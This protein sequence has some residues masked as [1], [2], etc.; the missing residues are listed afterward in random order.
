M[1]LGTRRL[2][3]LQL[4]SPA[5]RFD[6][7]LSN[8]TKLHLATAPVQ[9]KAQWYNDS[10][11]AAIDNAIALSGGPAWEEAGFATLVELAARAM[12]E[13]LEQVASAISLIVEDLATIEPALEALDGTAVE[14]SIR[15]VR[16][17]LA[18]LTY[19]GFVAGVGLERIDD[20]ARYIS[21]I[22]HRIGNLTESPA[23]DLSSAAACV[24][25]EQRHA[26]MV[27]ELGQTE[28]LEAVIWMLEE[29]R[30]SSFAQHL[31]GP[32]KVSATRVDRKLSEI[33][34][35]AGL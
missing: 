31:K 32:G 33:A 7:L 21:A 5:R 16:A 17:H 25:V 24:E 14:V 15:D 23:R 20:M 3:R 12:P 6:G 4:P 30:V 1:W 13:A 28:H 2:V 9:S 18:R 35:Q 11:D 27:A 34:R 19:P 29:L 10:I 26:R 22:R 8:R